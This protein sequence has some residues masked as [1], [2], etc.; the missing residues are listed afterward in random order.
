MPDDWI[1]TIGLVAVA[2]LAV[3]ALVSALRRMRSADVAADGFDL[4]AVALTSLLSVGLLIYR[5]V[6]VHA[7]WSPLESHVDGLLLL[8]AIVSIVVVYLRALRRLAGV[9]LFTSPLLLL[10]G[11]WGVCASWWTFAAFDARGVWD[12]GH[13]LVAYLAAAAVAVGAATGAMYLYVERQLRRRDDPAAQVR[14]LGKLADLETID[15]WMTRA[16][17]S[18]FVLISVVL[19]LG[20][21]DASTGV[22]AMG[23]RWLTDPKVIIAFVLWVLFAF[24]AHAHLAPSVRGARAAVM[25][26][27]GLI[28]M[29]AVMAMAVAAPGCQAVDGA[30]HIGSDGAGDVNVGAE[31]ELGERDAVVDVHD[32]PAVE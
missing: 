16:A 30:V 10:L 25:T 9:A 3:V 1:T 6:V 15:R 8:I 20:A 18:A 14:V 27:L 21:I 7:S 26:L 22:T 19:A 23:D 4:G 24:A 2:A 12:V 17:A 11:L 28:L 32:R 5:A 29:L 13:R 31:V